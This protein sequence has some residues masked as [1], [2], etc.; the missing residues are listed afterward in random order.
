MIIGLCFIVLLGLFTFTFMYQTSPELKI[1]KYSG[2]SDLNPSIKASCDKTINENSQAI[3][4]FMQDNLDVSKAGAS[5]S[6]V[7]NLYCTDC[8]ELI[9]IEKNKATNNVQLIYTYHNRYY[10]D[11]S[12]DEWVACEMASNNI[13]IIY[14]SAEVGHAS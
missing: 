9:T 14:A 6:E 3:I 13:P 10:S 2:Q 7:S 12:F 8:L 11:K 4:V 1:Q 5:K